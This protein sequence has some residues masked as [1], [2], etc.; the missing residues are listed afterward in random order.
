MDSL[1][2][3]FLLYLSLSIVSIIFWN[4]K[5]DKSFLILSILSILYF[6]V[7]ILQVVNQSVNLELLVYIAK[8][9]LLL[10]MILTTLYILRKNK[11]LLFLAIFG[12]IV[13]FLQFEIP[14]WLFNILSLPLF[15]Y[16]KL[17]VSK[18]MG[19]S[20]YYSPF[21]II[22]LSIYWWIL[23]GL[24][25]RA[26]YKNLKKLIRERRRYE[27]KTSKFHFD[28]YCIIYYYNKIILQNICIIN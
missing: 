11:F 13:P 17:F 3:F 5:R 23:I 6:I 28:F 27:S 7:L 22:P 18:N 26:I 14:N 24:I 10:G 20:D 8:L 15:I 19:G 2:I 16:V 21:I 12:L 25:I 4:I 9:F 1:I